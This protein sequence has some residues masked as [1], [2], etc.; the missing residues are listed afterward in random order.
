MMRSD[1]VEANSYSVLL[2]APSP[3]PYGGMAVQARLIQTLLR[4][5]GNTVALWTS[6]FA[7]PGRMKCLEKL[8]IL[9]AV[10]RFI[11][12]WPMLW[13]QMRSVDVVHVFAASWM[14]FFLVVCPAAS[15][16]RI[17]RKTVILNYHGGD[18][19]AFIRWFGWIIKPVFLSADIVTSP[20][21]TTADLIRGAFHL[22]VLAIPNLVD[23]QVFRY[24]LRTALQ[25]KLLV[26]RHLEKIYDIES[27]LRAFHLLQ[28][29][30]PEASLWIAGSGREELSLREIVSRC[31]LNNVLFL[32]HVNHEDLPDIYNQC[33][34][35]L[36][37]SRSDN[38]PV[39]LLEASIAGLAIVST[40]VGGITD[41]YKD[42]SNAL[43]VNPGDWASMAKAVD[44]LLQ[45]QS[46]A[47]TVVANAAAD[48]A[49]ICDWHAVRILLY[50][51][52]RGRGHRMRE[53]CIDR[54]IHPRYVTVNP[55]SED[56]DQRR[57]M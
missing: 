37:A 17:A 10:V 30:Y 40:R 19:K 8:R 9:R 26:T 38:S 48:V 21:E 20:S 11:L 3:P 57:A 1:T 16:G 15:L 13:M 7:L 25:P 12:I 4:R 47:L 29:Q 50:T 54:S 5:D 39:S 6:N 53:R 44:R 36:N 18:A 49:G 27:I 23:S 42:G 45:S 32:G 35:L 28:R 2:V 43:L 52:Y 14:Y 22:P 41:I 51:A 56:V 46:L 55:S 24:R 31:H 34:I 33:D